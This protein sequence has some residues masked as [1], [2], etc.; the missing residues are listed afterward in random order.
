V[1]PGLQ[2][3]RLVEHVQPGL[4]LGELLDQAQPGEIRRSGND[5]ATGHIENGELDHR[6]GRRREHVHAGRGQV[7]VGQQHSQPGQ[8]LP[9][10]QVPQLG[11]GLTRPAQQ[12]ADR[13][14]ARCEGV[15]RWLRAVHLRVQAP[16]VLPHLS[17]GLQ[18]HPLPRRL[19]LWR[20]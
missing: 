7:P 8:Q 14:C 20:Q 6:P 3:D 4:D 10:R 12:P 15:K 18:A 16:M 17:T 11:R 5:I 13:K 19:R 2:H 9:H 1:Q